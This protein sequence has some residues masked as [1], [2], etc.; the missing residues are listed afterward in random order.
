MLLYEAASSLKQGGDGALN[1]CIGKGLPRGTQ[2]P[3]LA[4]ATTVVVG[5]PLPGRAVQC[6][7]AAAKSIAFSVMT[8]FMDF[9]NGVDTVHTGSMLSQS[10]KMQDA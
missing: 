3:R 5:A 4:A 2:A 6:S 10:S 7:A 9:A 1:A 8:L